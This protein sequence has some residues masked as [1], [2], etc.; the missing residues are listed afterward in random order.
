LGIEAFMIPRVV[1]DGLGG[2][3]FGLGFI[4]EDGFH[5]TVAGCDAEAAAIVDDF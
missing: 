1:E 5:E 2:S 4:N 3:R